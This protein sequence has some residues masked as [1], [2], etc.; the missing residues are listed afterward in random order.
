ML[1]AK[2]GEIGKRQPGQS[3]RRRISRQQV[4][5][6]KTIQIPEGLQYL[7]VDP[8]ENI[9]QPVRLTGDELSQM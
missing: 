3:R 5:H 4:Q 8:Q 2:G 1:T 9:T 7:R 6:D